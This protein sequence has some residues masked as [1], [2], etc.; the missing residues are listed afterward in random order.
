MRKSKEDIFGNHCKTYIRD[1]QAKQ[2]NGN[3]ELKENNIS[4]PTFLY[5]W[6]LIGFCYKRLTLGIGN[7]IGENVVLK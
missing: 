5:S 7:G 4:N 2:E 3:G 1:V 6:G